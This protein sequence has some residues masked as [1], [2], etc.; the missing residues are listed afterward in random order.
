M[1]NIIYWQHKCNTYPL[2]NT[3]V[4]L[5]VATARTAYT[6]TTFHFAHG[7]PVARR[8]PADAQSGVGVEITLTRAFAVALDSAPAGV[9]NAPVAMRSLRTV[10]A[11]ASAH[12][13]FTRWRK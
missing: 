6:R 5:T 9:A 10:Y 2:T 1:K 12:G 11:L 4:P 8:E 3:H 13:R 7:A